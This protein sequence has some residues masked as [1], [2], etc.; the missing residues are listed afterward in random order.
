MN[1]T[2]SSPSTVLFFSPSMMPSIS[3]GSTPFSFVSHS[4]A[5]FSCRGDSG[6]TEMGLLIL[7]LPMECGRIDLNCYRHPRGGKLPQKLSYQPYGI[8]EKLT[9]PPRERRGS[10]L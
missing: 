8:I 1:R 4:K 2:N 10:P 5:F 9:Y 7:L 3:F 6:P